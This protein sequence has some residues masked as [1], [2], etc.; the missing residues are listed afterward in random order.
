LK[1]SFAIVLSANPGV[2]GTVAANSGGAA[3]RGR[4]APRS[5]RESC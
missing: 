2:F 5:T 3:I 4:E 1:T